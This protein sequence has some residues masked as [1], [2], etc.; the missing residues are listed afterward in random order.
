MTKTKAMTKLT[1]IRD[2]EHSCFQGTNIKWK[3]RCIGGGKMG[4]RENNNRK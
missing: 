4:K 1:R 3:N 2:P